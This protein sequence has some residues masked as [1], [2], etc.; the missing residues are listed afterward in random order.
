M[1]AVAVFSMRPSPKAPSTSPPMRGIRSALGAPTD[2]DGDALEAWL[3]RIAAARGATDRLGVLRKLS[4]Q[5]EA[6]PVRT[7]RV[8]DAAARIDRWRREILHGPGSRTQSS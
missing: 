6:H 4:R 7:S 2:L 5:V 8:L 1:I 3:D